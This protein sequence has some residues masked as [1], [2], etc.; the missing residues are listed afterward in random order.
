MASL[1]ETRQE[2]ARYAAEHCLRLEVSGLY[3]L[4]LPPGPGGGGAAARVAIAT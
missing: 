2:L 4:S 1:T 3:D